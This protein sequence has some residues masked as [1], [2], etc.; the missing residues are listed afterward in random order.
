MWPKNGQ[1]L[2]IVKE[3]G[4]TDSPC[5]GVLIDTPTSFTLAHLSA[6]EFAKMQS[7]I[8]IVGHTSAVGAARA[9]TGRQL[10]ILDEW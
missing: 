9:K 5:E 6:D 10:C 8:F 2:C 1:N 4:G 3:A 7:F